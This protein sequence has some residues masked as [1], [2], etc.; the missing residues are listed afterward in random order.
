LVWNK[1][2]NEEIKITELSEL[3]GK[4]LFGIENNITQQKLQVLE[5]SS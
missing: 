1:I 3:M 5:I 4:I 2:F